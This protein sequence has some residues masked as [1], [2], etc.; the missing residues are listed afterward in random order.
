MFNPVNNLFTG[1]H[2]REE[3][4]R[5][6]FSIINY[7]LLQVR[8]IQPINRKHFHSIKKTPQQYSKKKLKKGQANNHNGCT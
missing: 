6:V 7:T 5:N 8:M 4:D 2:K 3:R 1:G